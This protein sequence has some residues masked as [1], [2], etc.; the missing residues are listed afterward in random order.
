M[1]NVSKLSAGLITLVTADFSPHEEVKNT[2]RMFRD[3]VASRGIV[4]EFER[5]ASMDALDVGHV[6][7]DSGRFVQVVVNLLS[8]AIKFTETAARHVVS[9]RIGAVAAPPDGDEVPAWPE[10]DQAD[11][12]PMCAS[13]AKDPRA[14]RLWIHVAVADSGHGMSQDEQNRVFQRFAQASPKTYGEFGGHGLGL[15][16][17]LDSAN[18]KRA[19]M[20][21]QYVSRMLVELHGGRIHLQSTKDV[22]TVLRFFILV[23]RT[24]ATPQPAPTPVI[25]F[26]PSTSR[27]PSSSIV[28]G[29][30]AT[31]RRLRVLV[32]EVGFV[33]CTCDSVLIPPSRI[34]S[35]ISGCS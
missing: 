5:D 16:S 13:G 29:N 23:E 4:L 1:L 20:Q 8:N 35:S 31:P 7:G 27:A 18:R 26:K 19:L 12:L 28:T 21:L 30:A 24:T 32:V 9:V 14:G 2:V 17:L 34:T 11:L 3:E 33:V 6:R 15:V 25:E 22:G 10:M